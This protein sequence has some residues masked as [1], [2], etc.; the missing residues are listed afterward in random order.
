[1]HLDISL[2]MEMQKV[3]LE[4]TP[5]IILPVNSNLGIAPWICLACTF[6]YSLSL[7]EL[8]YSNCKTKTNLLS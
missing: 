2:E 4:I 7:Q 1:M 5:S 8:P 3:R 6:L